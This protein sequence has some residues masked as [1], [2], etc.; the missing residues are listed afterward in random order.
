MQIDD[1]VRRLEDKVGERDL[2][3]YERRCGDVGGRADFSP[4][5]TL[6]QVRAIMLVDYALIYDLIRAGE[7][8]AFNFSGKKITREDVGRDTREIRVSPESLRAY[9]ERVR[10]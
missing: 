8:E 9:L 3:S 4:L 2:G 7:L 10:L 6:S 5:L 1:A